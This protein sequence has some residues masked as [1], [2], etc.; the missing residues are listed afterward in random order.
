MTL[1]TLERAQPLLPFAQRGGR[2]VRAW[3]E[4]EA[5][6]MAAL[7]NGF[8]RCGH[9]WHYRIG[10]RRYSLRMDA[11]GRALA[12]A[13]CAIDDPATWQSEALEWVSNR[14]PAWTAGR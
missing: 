2:N 6:L 13:V 5:R 11:R 9:W 7:G 4:A 3:A 14:E 10:G 12:L 8:W 1:A